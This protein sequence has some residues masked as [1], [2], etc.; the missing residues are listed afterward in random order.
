MKKHTDIPQQLQDNG[1]DN[2]ELLRSQ[3][4]LEGL[5]LLQNQSI[6]EILKYIYRFGNSFNELSAEVQCVED[7]LSQQTE[8]IGD[9]EAKHISLEAKIKSLK[10]QLENVRGYVGDRL[11]AAQE[12]Y[13]ASTDE[14]KTG[15]GNLS[16]MLTDISDRAD[17]IGKE[18]QKSYEAIVVVDE[19]LSD[20]DNRLAGTQSNIR[21]AIDDIG[22]RMTSAISESESNLSEKLRSTEKALSKAVSESTDATGRKTVSAIAESVEQA[23]KSFS[24][25]VT[26]AAEL[27]LEKATSAIEKAEGSLANAVREAAKEATETTAEAITERIEKT[28]ESLSQA[29]RESAE[30]SS[31]K[32]VSAISED[33]SKTKTDITDNI[34]KAKTDIEASVKTSGA[35]I[36]TDIDG[37]I[38]K[39]SSENSNAVKT[40]LAELSAGEKRLDNS[41]KSGMSRL[42]DVAGQTDEKIKG[43]IVKVEGAVSELSG[44]IIEAEKSVEGKMTA[45]SS[46]TKEM[47]DNIFDDISALKSESDRLAEELNNNSNRDKENNKAMLDAIANDKKNRNILIDKYITG[48]WNLVGCEDGFYAFVRE[49]YFTNNGISRRNRLVYLCLEFEKGNYEQV[50]VGLK[51]YY[52]KFGESLIEEYL[53]LAYIAH[54]IGITNTL[55]EK[56]AAIFSHLEEN[57]KNDTFYNYINGRK[58]A[59]V[60]NSP[61]IL[62]TGAG[63][64][65]DSCDVVFRMNTFAM[66]KEHKKDI[67]SKTTAFVDNANFA[68][69]D[70]KNHVECDNYELIYIP[71]DF[72]H[73]AVSQFCSPQKFINSLYEIITEK[74][75]TV[76]SFEPSYSAELKER[77]GVISPSAGIII[78]WHIYRRIGRL[79]RKWVYG[80]T[81]EI[82]EDKIIP[83]DM[84][85]AGDEKNPA[86]AKANLDC[87]SEKASTSAFFVNTPIYGAGASHNYNKEL[88]LRLEMFGES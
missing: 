84:K 69:I 31:E 39:Y 4:N 3:K 77:L 78:L 9:I 56:S 32:L 13:L 61:S 67:G 66:K 83:N 50:K 72:W 28:E 18:L 37:A 88:R 7:R 58:F 36:H 24:D 63:K 87:F 10:E 11:D 60:G 23:E 64:K 68:T 44:R 54:S 79:D 43:K 71:Y 73:I 40:V 5:I 80:F 47:L 59:V 27:T 22:G 1:S 20:T 25:T 62:G 8:R 65:I 14:A 82:N 2:K 42:S 48:M 38:K 17:D 41:F 74:K 30:A 55:I 45:L 52:D 16:L 76:C 19:R 49:Q 46:S 51:A 57:R 33:I 70:H 85:D 29:I 21:A 34:A 75:K 26:R 81:E 15:I 12:K 53:P 86:I 6:Q 35:S